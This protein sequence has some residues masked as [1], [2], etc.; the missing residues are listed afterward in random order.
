MDPRIS[1][2]TLGVTDLGR[3]TK[4]YSD[5][6]WQQAA[7]EEGISAFNLH[8]QVLG[9]YPMEKLAEDLGVDAPTLGNFSGVTLGHNV[10]SREDVDA[11]MALAEKIGAK[12]VR[13]AGE[14]FWG[15][16]M[17]YFAD[18]DG[19]VWEVAHNPFSPLGPNGEF[20]WGGVEPG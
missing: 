7:E 8:G 18:P 14:I 20:Q 19:H 9:L 10:P 17:G 4:F 3:S 11:L 13:P 6:G 12:I 15:G 16:Y 2:I 5:L 1:L